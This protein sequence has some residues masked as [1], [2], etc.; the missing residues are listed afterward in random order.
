MRCGTALGPI[1]AIFDGIRID[2]HA[3]LTVLKVVLSCVYDEIITA[4]GLAMA[5][6]SFWQ[7]HCIAENFQRVEKLWKFIIQR[8]NL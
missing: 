5:N 8:I 4:T 3:G 1:P 2:M 7:F 6:Y